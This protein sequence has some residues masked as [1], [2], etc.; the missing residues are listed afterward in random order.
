MR[1]RTMS[2][3]TPC[4]LQN[5]EFVTREPSSRNSSHGLSAYDSITNYSP[6]SA[7]TFPSPPQFRGMW[8][9]TWGTAREWGPSKR[10]EALFKFKGFWNLQTLFGLGISSKC[11]WITI[12][13]GIWP[14][15]LKQMVFLARSFGQSLKILE[16][17]RSP[18]L[19]MLP[20]ILIYILPNSLDSGLPW[21]MLQPWLS[22]RAA[23]V[24]TQDFF[25]ENTLRTE[26]CSTI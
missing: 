15:D 5:V 20:A 19:G 14:F 2:S 10:P 21:K 12:T 18:S 13:Y 23:V 17:K 7:P 25:S 26:I 8:L 9:V 24:P 22:H 16:I 3:S 6:Y 1:K 11:L 4:I